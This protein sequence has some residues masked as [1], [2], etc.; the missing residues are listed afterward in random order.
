MVVARK[1]PKLFAAAVPMAAYY[2]AEKVKIP[3]YAIHGEKDQIFAVRDA[4]SFIKKSKAKGSFIELKI[5]E[6]KSH[7]EAC[8]YAEALENIIKKV[9]KQVLKN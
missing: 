9:E 2:S 5:L 7:Y 8:S 6:E 1:Y 4:Q 3:V